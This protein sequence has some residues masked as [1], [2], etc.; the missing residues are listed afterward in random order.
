MHIERMLGPFLA[1]KFIGLRSLQEWFLAF[2]DVRRMEFASV[3]GTDEATNHL[4]DGQ[5]LFLTNINATSGAM[6][7]TVCAGGTEY[8][9]HPEPAD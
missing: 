7:G 9:E 4:R 8:R 6:N 5:G 2:N 1:L 3:Y